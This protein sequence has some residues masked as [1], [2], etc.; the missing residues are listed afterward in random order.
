MRLLPASATSP[1]DM[2][3]KPRDPKNDPQVGGFSFQGSQMHS[4][5]S[6]RTSAGQISLTGA[7]RLD[8]GSINSRITQ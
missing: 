3:A 8:W 1:E 7:E 5:G 2:G 4:K 6:C